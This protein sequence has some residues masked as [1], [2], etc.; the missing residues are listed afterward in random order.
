MTFD[1][2]GFLAPFVI[3]GSI[4]ALHTMLPA[5]HVEGYVRDAE[6]VALRYR[7]NGMLVLLVSVSAWGLL[8]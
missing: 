5:R 6:G 7:L 3:Y 4:L 1:L 2:V 8:G